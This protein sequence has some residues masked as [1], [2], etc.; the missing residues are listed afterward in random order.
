MKQDYSSDLVSV[1]VPTYNRAELIVAALDSVFQQTYRPIEAIV[2]DD[3]STDGTV[4]VVQNWAQEKATTDPAFSVRYLRQ[5]NSGPSAARNVGLRECSGQ[6]IQFLDADD[7]LHQKK[8][9][10][11][12]SA[13]EENHADFCVCNYQSFTDSVSALGPVVDFHSRSHSISDFPAQYP[14]DTP[15]PLYRR[16]VIAA[17]GPWDERLS[18]GEDFEYNF[19]IVSK[20]AKGAWLEKVLL[21]VRKHTGAERIQAT[22]LSTRYQSMYMGLAAMEMQAIGQGVCSREFLNSLGIRAYQYYRHTKAE[23]SHHEADIFLRYARPRLFLATKVYFGA[24]RFLPGPLIK[25]CV[26]AKRIVRGKKR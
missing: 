13:I 7:I 8:L 16:E 24:K 5:D 19:R 9:A 1:I 18:A 12:V 25:A 23:G 10:M 2:V 3:G 17:N 4:N 20:G 22:P 26:A 15:A 21:Y 11:Q 14:M 6:F